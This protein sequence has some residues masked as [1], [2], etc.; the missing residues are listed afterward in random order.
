MTTD[1]DKKL[2]DV[3]SLCLDKQDPEKRL[4]QSGTDHLNQNN[5]RV[6]TQKTLLWS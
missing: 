4:Y 1:G 3:I 2:Y 6:K 5:W